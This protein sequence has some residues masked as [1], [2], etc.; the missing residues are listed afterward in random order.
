MGV[1]LFSTP[2]LHY[3]CMETNRELVSYENDNKYLKMSR[4][5]RTD[6]HKVIFIDD[7]DKSDILKPWSIAFI[8][9]APHHR[10]AVD[11]GRLANY[12][13]YIICH[14]SEPQNDMYYLYST[15]YSLFKYRFDY[16]KLFPYTTVLSNF[17]TLDW[18]EE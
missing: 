3:I 18:L 13:E 15:I 14:D 8:D 12:A 4:G 16:T 17:H 2:L 10:R 9:H 7:W 11:A 6:F 5:F 1:G